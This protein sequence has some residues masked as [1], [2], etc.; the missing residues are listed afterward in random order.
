MIYTF[1]YLHKYIMYTK[2]FAYVHDQVS[3]FMIIVQ[4]WKLKHK[5]NL[6]RK[7]LPLKSQTKESIL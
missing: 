1:W 4:A 6:F 2:M 3:W 5:R 7:N